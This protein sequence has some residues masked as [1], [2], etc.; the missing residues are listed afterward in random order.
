[1]IGV[2]SAT[3]TPLA[4][5]HFVGTPIDLDVE[6]LALGLDQHFDEPVVESED[7][8]RRVAELLQA[9]GQPVALQVDAQPLRRFLQLSLNLSVAEP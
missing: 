8:S 5:L 4:R 7:I 1:M 9:N 2:G 3:S 6:D